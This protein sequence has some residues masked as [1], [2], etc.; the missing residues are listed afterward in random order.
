M[1]RSPPLISVK[2]EPKTRLDETK[3]RQAVAE[4]VGEDPRL[5]FAVDPESGENI[6]HGVCELQL[7]AVVGELMERGIGVSAGAP[8]I[9]YLETLSGSTEVDYTLDTHANG[10]RQFARLTLK[11][12]QN[13]N[14]AGNEFLVALV[15]DALPD[16]FIAGVERGINNT[17]QNGILIG[18]PMA[19]T[20]VTLVHAVFHNTASSAKAFEIA[21]RAAMKDGAEITGIVLLEPIMDVEV[22]TPV[23]CVSSIAADLDSRRAGACQRE[24][25]DEDTIII[26]AKVPLALLFGYVSSLRSLSGGR[27]SH[28]KTFSHYEEVPQNIAPDPDAFPPAVGMRAR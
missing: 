2:V 5:S 14:G 28:V 7:D 21:A 22:L 13:G 10:R 3:L 6:I 26:R 20:K 23:D 15:D 27:A 16:E 11:I 18:F 17:W 4:L 24:T 19:D 1:Y 12:E 8:L 9:A 25:R